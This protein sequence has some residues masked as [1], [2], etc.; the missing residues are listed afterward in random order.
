M[1]RAEL[2]KLTTTRGPKIAVAVGVLGVAATQLAS[3]WLLPAISH[4]DPDLAASVEEMATSSPEQQL[5]ALNVLGGGGALGSG[6]V[7]IGLVAV[8]LL[9]ALIATSDY[10]HGGIV[11]SALA[12]PQRG[13]IMAAKIGVSVL[14]LAVTGLAYALVQG[15]LVALAPSTL[16][17][18]GFSANWLEG[19]DVLGRGVL[20]LLPLGILGL[21]AGMLIRSQTATFLV[22]IGAAVADVTAGAFLAL[23]PATREWA[24]YTPLSLVSTATGPEGGWAAVLALGVLAM[25]AL[26]AAVA[27][28]LTL[29][30]RDL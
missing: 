6:S 22:L 20:T 19:A 2:L 25:M 12:A 21:A 8:L 10:R 26:V 3:G 4:V 16:G 18:G 24:G 15:I 30:R 11:T 23:V 13:R 5:A 1:I 29:R 27:A 7:S 14:A 17:A 28:W 9:G